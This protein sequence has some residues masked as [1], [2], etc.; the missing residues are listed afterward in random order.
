[1]ESAN[2]VTIVLPDGTKKYIEDP[3]PI[4]FDTGDPY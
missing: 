1:M 3:R 2:T 4:G